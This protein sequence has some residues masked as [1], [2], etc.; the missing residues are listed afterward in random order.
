M[1]ILIGAVLA[2]LSIAVILYPFLRSR[3]TRPP[4]PAGPS[5]AE[6]QGESADNTGPELEAIYEAIRTLQLEHQLGNVPR[7][8][9]REQLDA[10]RIQAAMALKRQIEGHRGDA[11]WALEQEISVARASLAQYN[12]HPGRCANCGSVVTTALVH[13]PEC[14]ADLGDHRGHNGGPDQA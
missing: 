13:C 8:L 14:N 2:I 7:G 4:S 3:N 5:P 9:Y 12:G 11:E 10:Y 6:G 1:A